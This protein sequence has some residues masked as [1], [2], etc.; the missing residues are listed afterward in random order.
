MLY[1][2]LGALPKALARELK[3]K[4]SPGEAKGLAQAPWDGQQG[5]DRVPT[6]SQ[7]P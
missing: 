1:P 6:H 5:P 2:K 3:E 4:R 7:L